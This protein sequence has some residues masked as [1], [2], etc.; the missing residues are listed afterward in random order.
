M[1]KGE[2]MRQEGYNWDRSYDYSDYNKVLAYYQARAVI[3]NVS[4]ESLLDLAC[5]DGFITSLLSSKYSRVVGVDASLKHVEDARKNCSQAEFHESL[6][7]DLSVNE[8]FDVVT[9]LNILEHVVNPIEI[10]KKAASFLNDD[11]TL[12]VQ[13]PNALAINRKMATIMGT[14]TDE[15]ELSPYDINV[16]GHR[17]SYDMQLLIRD[18]E[19]AGLRPVNTGG[20]F[21]KMFSTPQMDWFLK[22]GLWDSGF[23]WGRV[24]AEKDKD[25][26]AE[27]CR[28]CYEIGK[29]RPEECN[30]IFVCGKKFK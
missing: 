25:W 10:L 7:E 9:M 13:V 2:K 17:R 18:F 16:V 29:Q 24:G 12:V 20:V 1:S 11:G 22:N 30:V 28:A 5:G 4:G 8:K 21:F 27:F 6:I 19:T 23:G 3:E 15:Y 26:K 14:L